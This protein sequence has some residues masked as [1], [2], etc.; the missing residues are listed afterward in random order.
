MER[1]LRHGKA[2]EDFRFGFGL[3]V[4]FPAYNDAPSL[5]GLLARTF[6]VLNA[7]VTDFEVIVV[8]DGSVDDTGRVL[9]QMR[10]EY[11][12]RLRIV[13]HAVNRGYGGALRSGFAA[14]TK[15]FVFYTDGDGQYDVLELPSLLRLAGP[16][17]GL[18]N[19]YKTKR[20]DPWHRI[21]IGATYNAFARLL[22]GVKLRDIDCDYRLI[23]RAT[24][25]RIQL[26]STS[27]TVCVELVKKIE[28][29]GTRVLEVPVSHLPR[30]FGSSQFFRIR[31]LL[32]TLRQLLALHHTVVLR[33]WWDAVRETARRAVTQSR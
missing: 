21:W 18:V 12:D 31:S 25:E 16:D 22:F 19:G 6:R 10:M 24:L 27:G 8:N 14:A 4:F 7:H 3:S 5:P 20:H 1:V 2:V 30:L 32:Q 28:Q 33:P 13:T 9:E 23:R 29:T 15:E 11:G 17:V 26:T